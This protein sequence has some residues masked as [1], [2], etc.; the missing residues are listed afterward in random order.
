MLS[1]PEE[2]GLPPIDGV[3]LGAFAF[4]GARGELALVGIG[5]VAILAG[6]ERNWLLEVVLDVTCRAGDLGM[7]AQKRIFCFGVIEIKACDERFPTAGSV[8]RVA[9]LFEFAAMRIAMTGR[10]GGEI[11]VLVTGLAAG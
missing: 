6:G 5:V 8:A 11:H 2:R 7:L 4:L 1:D 10:A 9:G 3:A